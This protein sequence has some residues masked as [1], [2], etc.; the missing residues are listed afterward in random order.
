MLFRSSVKKRKKKVGAFGAF[1][2][3]TRQEMKRVNWPD[4]GAV[5]KATILILVIVGFS[6]LFIAGVDM[7]FAKLFELL[8]QV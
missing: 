3:S 1:G 4:R 8:R 6:L 7:V 2:E 5:T